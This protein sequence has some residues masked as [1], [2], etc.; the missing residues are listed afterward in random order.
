MSV[1]KDAIEILEDDDCPRFIIKTQDSGILIGESGKNF[2][3]LNHI[4]KKIVDKKFG[5]EE[6]HSARIQFSIDINDYQAKKME[7][8][9]NSA[10]IGAQKVRY[11]K[12]EVEM[13]PMSSYERR[14]VHS[15]LSE[16]P[17]ITTESAGE[18]PGRRVVIKPY[19][20]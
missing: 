16:Y 1:K 20:L 17:D 18:G 9:K 7:E 3:A 12:R 14:V 5:S 4:L 6:D 11:F 13:E 10:R 19:L 2:I 15:V 8:L